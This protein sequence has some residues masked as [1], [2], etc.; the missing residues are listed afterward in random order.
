MVSMR[1]KEIKIIQLDKLD[2]RDELE[3]RPT[4]LEELEPIQ[5]DDD[6]E[7]LVYVGSR[8]LKEIKDLLI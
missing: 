6:P 8:L 5:L 1:K 7:H 4:P 2:M 3:I